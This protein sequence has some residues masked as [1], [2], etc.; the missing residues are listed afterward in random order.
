MQEEIKCNHCNG[1]FYLNSFRLQEAKTVTCMYC[2]KRI[3]KVG[4]CSNG[5]KN[6]EMHLLWKKKRFVS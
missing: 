1:V 4:V 6:N 3:K 2:K 5:E